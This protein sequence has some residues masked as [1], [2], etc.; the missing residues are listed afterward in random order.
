MPVISSA[1]TLPVSIKLSP[2]IS[3]VT[4]S[5]SSVPTSVIF[6]CDAVN[7][8]PSTLVNTPVPALTLPATTLPV[9]SSS[10]SVPTSVI[11]G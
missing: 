6:G 3:P 1:E 7:N 10:S 8:V 9:T 2:D 5:S 4:S 11:F